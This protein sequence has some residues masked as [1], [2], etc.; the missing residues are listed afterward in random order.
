MNKME[1]MLS[2]ESSIEVPEMSP[3]DFGEMLDQIPALEEMLEE[4]KARLEELRK[5][6]KENSSEIETLETEIGELQ[7][8]I[9]E[10]KEL[11]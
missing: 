4:R 8:E 9:S 3:E 2:V 1:K 11:L 10:R 5:N 7:T 6:P